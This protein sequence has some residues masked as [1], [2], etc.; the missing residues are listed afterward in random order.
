MQ[1]FLIDFQYINLLM[2]IHNFRVA[3]TARYFGHAMQILIYVIYITL[4]VSLEF[5]C[6]HGIWKQENIRIAWLN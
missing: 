3:K 4:F 5:D 6:L 1:E 2:F